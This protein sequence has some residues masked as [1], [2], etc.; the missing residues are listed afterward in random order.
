[1]VVPPVYARRPQRQESLHNIRD[2]EMVNTIILSCNIFILSMLYLAQQPFPCLG[3]GLLRYRRAAPVVVDPVSS[4]SSVQ[5]AL[6][7]HIVAFSRIVPCLTGY[8]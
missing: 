4:T 1:M 2:I 5:L 7:L 6:L 3:E 8:L